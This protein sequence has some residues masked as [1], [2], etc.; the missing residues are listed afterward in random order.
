M[1]VT[2]HFSIIILLFLVHGLCFSQSNRTG[3]FITKEDKLRFLDSLNAYRAEIGSIPL[4]YSFQ[5]DSLARL[6]VA[7]IFR[8][9][10]SISESEYKSDYVAALHYKFKDDIRD[11]DKKNVHPDTVLAFHG[12]CSARLSKL[13]EPDDLIS[14]LFQ[15]WKNSP[16][17]WE[18]MLDSKYQHMMLYWFI[19]NDRH[20]RLRKGTIAVLLM[21]TKAENETTRERRNAQE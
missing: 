16:E 13:S 8:H 5:E 15:G 10:D 17:H 20:I 3:N 21:Y 11:Y 14:E 6:R 2:M 12:E 4:Q 19:D 1:G 7:T 18:M 9:V